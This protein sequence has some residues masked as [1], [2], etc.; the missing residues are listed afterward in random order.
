VQAAQ[1]LEWVTELHL[2]GR[3]LNDLLPSGSN[4][5]AYLQ[6]LKNWRKPHASTSDDQWSRRV[7]EWPWPAHVQGHWQRFGDQAGLEIK[8]RTTSPADFNKK[9]E[10]LLSIR[11]TW[12]CN[13]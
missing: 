6:R 5:D 7:N 12:S 11:D 1:A 2:M 10:R 8:I 9:L 3:P 4:A 13:S